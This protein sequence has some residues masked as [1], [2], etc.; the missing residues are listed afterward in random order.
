M[1]DHPYPDIEAFALGELD[2]Q[3]ASAVLDH[4]DR[5]PSC[6]VLV[7]DAMHALA[8]LTQIDAADDVAPQR[9]AP[10]VRAARRWHPAWIAA[11]LAAAAALLLGVR[12][13][14]VSR[15][16]PPIAALV[17]SHF[18]HHELT[19]AAPLSGRVKVLQAVD[20]RWLYVVGDGFTPGS[21]WTLYERATPTREQQRVGEVRAGSDGVLAAYFEQ[22][23]ATIDALS[24]EPAAGGARYSWSNRP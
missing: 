10:T 19:S 11:G 23:A 12:D 16:A 1:N 7:A 9:P 5:C 8:G 2:P 18:A 22:R 6:A 13:F 15:Q 14:E 17:H 20:G 24:L 21:S 4:A 3:A